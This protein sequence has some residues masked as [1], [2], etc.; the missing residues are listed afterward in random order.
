MTSN[1]YERSHGSFKYHTSEC[2][3]YP[4]TR[5]HSST[6][7]SKAQRVSLTQTC[8][9][10][11]D[12]SPL[13]LSF[14]YSL[15]SLLLKIGSVKRRFKFF[16][17]SC[18]FLGHLTPEYGDGRRDLQRRT[19]WWSQHV[20][21]DGVSPFTEK[22]LSFSLRVKKWST[23]GNCSECEKWRKVRFTNLTLAL[24]RRFNKADI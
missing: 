24:V 3:L 12:S 8:L 2:L 7:L 20:E 5:G 15:S 10:L 17:Q 9:C 18:N 1:A 19:C 14:L 16:F 6:V 23:S 21:K 22:S 11:T 4:E 13:N